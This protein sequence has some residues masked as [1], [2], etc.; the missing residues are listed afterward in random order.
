MMKS[1]MLFLGMIALTLIL[2]ACNQ[3]KEEFDDWINPSPS[4]P[5]HDSGQPISTK[6]VD[7]PQFVG[8]SHEITGKRYALVVANADYTGD[9][10]IPPL[11]NPLNDGRDMKK[12]LKDVGFNVT[13]RENTEDKRQLKEAVR[14]F[15]GQLR[16]GDVGV[17]YYAGH[18][19]QVEGEN[20]L[21]PTQVPLPSQQDVKYETLSAQY[22]LDQ[23]EDAGNGFNIVLLDACRDNPLPQTRTR[24]VG[25]KG[26]L[27]EMRQPKGSIIGF[28]TSPNDTAADGT[29][30]NGIYT[31][32]LLEAI[33]TPGLT[34]EQ[35]LKKVRDGVWGE[36]QGKQVPWE[37][38]SLRGDFCFSGCE[39][40]E[41][42]AAEEEQ[43]RLQREIARLKAELVQKNKQQLQG[44]GYETQKQENRQ[45]EQRLNVLED[46]LR[47]IPKKQNNSYR[48][49]NE[50]TVIMP[51]AL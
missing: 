27:A 13:Y 29:G 28:A 38:S 48:R 18:A 6:Q 34:V 36:T 39:K 20:Y 31:K 40:K 3:L 44:A 43:L 4:K 7:P 1:K 22:V 32:H 47:K 25:K 21:L 24:S 14:K 17:F 16:P 45:L 42:K 33:K 5:K 41:D 49:R 23:M 37:N 46:L 12:A 30:K 26:G 19:V 15:T 2:T 11:K 50:D 51:P 10:N 9:P 35:M 8:T